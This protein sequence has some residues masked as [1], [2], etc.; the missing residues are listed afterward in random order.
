MR[1]I[2]VNIRGQYRDWDKARHSI[3]AMLDPVEP[4][5]NVVY[6]FTTWDIS[7]HMVGVANG[8]NTAYLDYQVINDKEVIGDSFGDRLVGGIQILSTDVARNMLDIRLPEE[9]ELI[10]FMRHAANNMKRQYEQ[11]NDMVF[12]IVIETRPDLYVVPGDS[13]DN[14][15]SLDDNPL[16]DFLIQCDRRLQRKHTIYQSS[17]V[18]SSVFVNDLMFVCNS[19]TA[20]LLNNEL[21]HAIENTKKAIFKSWAHDHILEYM[22]SQKMVLDQGLWRYYLDFELVRPQV[23]PRSLNYQQANL[24][25]IGY[26]RINHNIFDNLRID[27]MSTQKANLVI[28]M[29][30]HGSRFADEG[31]TNPKPFIDV[32]GQPMIA[33]VVESLGLQA[34][35]KHIF[36][37]RDEH[38]TPERTDLLKSL[39]HDV[40]IIVIDHVTRGAAETVLLAKDA[41]NTDGELFIVNSDQLIEWNM[42]AFQQRMKEQEAQGGILTF[43]GQGT[44]WSYAATDE[45]AQSIIRV[46]EKEQIS[47]DATAGLYYFREGRFFIESAQSMIDQDI[48]TNNEFYVAPVYNEFIKTRKAIIFPVDAVYQLGTP[49]E[50]EAYLNDQKN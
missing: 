2:A 30:G 5:A 19:F 21:F 43:K 3:F 17:N 8:V 36:I 34:Y 7:Y 42:L 15:I 46:A 48:R 40:E 13:V 28:P 1:T 27:K 23:I 6:F 29:A 12:D 32:N 16:P 37:C 14:I 10:M 47:E 44:N 20:D 24:E 49:I 50:L 33:R 22:Y 38:L 41:Y 25:T 18:A 39:A 26:I 35:A 31:Y 45:F 9:Y 4:H 11:D